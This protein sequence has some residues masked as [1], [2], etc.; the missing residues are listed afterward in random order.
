MP[1][2]FVYLNNTCLS[3]FLCST[4]KDLFRHLQ[5]EIKHENNVF[6]RIYF[7]NFSVL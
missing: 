4:E 1:L 6:I 5:R 2:T 7:Q 3:L